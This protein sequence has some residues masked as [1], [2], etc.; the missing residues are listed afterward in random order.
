MSGFGGFGG[1]GSNNN[2]QQGTG[3]GFGG[4]GNSGTNTGFGTNATSSPFGQNKTGFGATATSSGGGLFGAAPATSNNNAFGGFGGGAAT[5]GFGGSTLN[6]GGGLFGQSKPAFGASTTGATGG[7]I[8]GGGGTGFG[9]G[10]TGSTPAFGSGASTTFGNTLQQNS[11][12]LNPPFSEFVEK[13]PAATNTS[14]RYQTISTMQPYQ[15]YSLEELRL[16]DYSQG[17]KQGNANGQA[18]AFGTGTG[19][20]GFGASGGGTTGFGGGNTSTGGGIFG[21][22][23]SATASS[24]GQQQQTA[25][26]GF[27]AGGASGGLF[28]AKPATGGLFGS[29]PA[30]SAQTGGG[31]FGTSGTSFGGGNTTG[32]GANTTTGTTGGLFGSTPAKPAFGGFGTGAATGA[33]TGFGGSTPFGG[34]ATSTGGT[35][36][37]GN[38]PAAPATGFGQQQQSTSTPFSFG[39]QGQQNQQQQPQTGTSLFGG[40]GAQNQ[41]Q[42]PGGLF[43]TTNT[44]STGGGLFGNSSQQQQPAT[45]GGLFGP[46]TQQQGGGGLFGNKPATGGLFGN[47]PAANTGGGGLFGNTQQQQAPT[48]GLFGQSA[49][50]PSGGLFGSKPAGSGLGSSLFNQPSQQQQTGTSLFGNTQQQQPALGGSLFGNSQSQQ[51][52]P[53]ALHAS[54][55]DNPYGNDQ[56]FASLAAPNQSVGPLATPLSSTPKTKKQTLIPSYRMQPAASNRLLTPQRRPQAYGFSYSTYGTPGSAITSPTMGNSLLGN[57]LNR[58]LN[59]SL[60]TSNLRHSF[61]AQDSVLMPGAFSTTGRSG[62]STLKK[63]NINKNTSVR[64][65]LF[66]N[67]GP[68]YAASSNVRKSVSFEDGINGRATNWGSSYEPNNT[69]AL[70]RT[71]TTEAEPDTPA[72]PPKT[73]AAMPDMDQV[74]GVGRGKELAVVHEEATSSTTSKQ[75]P[76]PLNPFNQKDQQPGSY[77]MR[78]SVQEINQMTP[79][80]K[81]NFQGLTVGREGCGK[82]TFSRVDLNS[83][84][85]KDIMGKIVVFET[86]SCTVYGDNAG[87]VKPPQGQGL[88]VRSTISLE[89]SWPRVHEGRTLVLEKKGARVEKHLKRLKRLPDTK[90][91]SYENGVWTFEVEHFTTYGLPDDFED[92]E[93][94]SMVDSSMLS[95]APATPTPSKH[96][97]GISHSSPPLNS[98]ASLPSPP[99]SSPDDTFDFKK[100]KRKNLPGQ[101]EEEDVYDEDMSYEEDDQTNQSFLGERSVGSLGEDGDEAMSQMS[102]SGS[103]A[104]QEMAGSFPAPTNTTEQPLATFEEV[105]LPKSILKATQP[106]GTPMKGGTLRAFDDWTEQLQRTASPKKQDRQALRANQSAAYQQLQEDHD[107]TPKVA[108]R[109][110]PFNTPMD[111]MNSLL[112]QS[113]HGNGS[114]RG[115]FGASA[116]GFQNPNPKRAKTS[117]EIDAQD[118]AFHNTTKPNWGPDGTF[119]YTTTPVSAHHNDGVVVNFGSSLVGEHADVRFAKISAS[120]DLLSRAIA[121]Q[122]SFTNTTLENGVPRAETSDDFVFAQ[123]SEVVSLETTAGRKEKQVWDLASILFDHTDNRSGVMEP[124]VYERFFRKDQLSSFWKKVVHGDATSAASKAATYEEKALHYLSGG[125]I[126]EAC[127]ALVEGRNFHLASLVAQIGGDSTFREVVRQQLEKWAELN[128]LAEFNDDVRAIYELLSGNTSICK[129]RTRHGAE[130]NVSTFSISTRFGLDWRRAFGLWLWYGIKEQEDLTAAVQQFDDEL[131]TGTEKA[132]PIPWFV[133]KG[134]DMGWVDPNPESREDILWT[135]LKLYLGSLAGQDFETALAPENVSGNPMNT[136][137]SF[138]LLNIF[139]ALEIG[140][141]EGDSAA[142]DALA[143]T[144]ASGLA[145]TVSSDPQNLHTTCWVLM[146]LS[147]RQAREQ[148]IRAV[149]DQHAQLLDAPS[150]PL[151]TR[152]CEL[153]VPPQWMHLSRALYARAVTHDPVAEAQSLIDA[154]EWK[155]AHDVVCQV[156]G[157]AAVIEQDSDQLRELLGSLVEQKEGNRM[158]WNKG[159]GM[160]YD[161]VELKDLERQRGQRWKELVVRLGRALE[162]VMGEGLEGKDLKESAALQIMG[163]TV[164]QIAATTDVMDKGQALRL[165]LTEDAYLQHSRALSVDYYRAILA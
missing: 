88:N 77:W 62:A 56:L 100:G 21:G 54:L 22:S 15:G 106:F 101:F 141:I 70:V 156:I 137:L 35:G 94:Q 43:G 128:V 18:G 134:V 32:F 45:G 138:Q 78:P 161:F 24:F 150:G 125:M 28:G 74:N 157:P 111:I 69:Q 164:A 127:T 155:Q 104:E 107:P 114:V 25:T 48:G 40:F 98:D 121:E 72:P 151:F 146:H 162:G 108:S 123:L 64:R 5:S 67:D 17:R 144:F 132:R 55:T 136:R 44:T 71:E 158:E 37:F 102:E 13:D 147:G 81:K 96:S 116:R 110:K 47:A 75:P 91:I 148:S 93:D 160:Y 115:K 41:Q 31:L 139:R 87:V 131:V 58:S 130:N 126:E 73:R 105:Q 61:N 79:T 86:R 30:T 50:Q 63:L 149:L 159:A 85:I 124:E 112:N 9:S 29:T 153:R 8:F 84:N 89:N 7:G 33:S 36:L 129:G 90:F 12:T 152:L 39:Q 145:T 38:A 68:D 57:G 27:G 51:Q 66:G 19:F 59:K 95:D 11:G 65:P 142:A 122:Q 133:E 140:D 1:F 120:H 97:H 117:K 135:L 113:Q 60:S 16:A 82:V 2:Q 118:I 53:Q 165:P 119:V 20:G 3:S 6:T 26:T 103:E 163:A 92:D 83:V 14:N 52:Q 4:F 10:A 34:A 42:K 109:N 76:P 99:E 46:T 154:G 49:Q 23:G 143:T 80:Q